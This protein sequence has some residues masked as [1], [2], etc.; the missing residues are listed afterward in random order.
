[1]A[2]ALNDIPQVSAVSTL[3]PNDGTYAGYPGDL[4]INLTSA[5]TDR[6]L[7]VM[8]GSARVKQTTGW[9]PV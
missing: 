3:N 5:S 7:L 9:V 2:R 8:G 6:R 1:M 4:L